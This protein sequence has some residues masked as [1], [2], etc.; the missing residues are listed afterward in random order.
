MSQMESIIAGLL[1]TWIIG[2]EIGHAVLGHDPGASG[3]QSKRH[4]R[5][6]DL[7][8][9][10]RLPKFQDVVELGYFGITQLLYNWIRYELKT[11]PVDFGASDYIGAI[12][13]LR[14][15]CPTHPPML[16]RLLDLM[17]TFLERFPKLDKTG[18]FNR[19]RSRVEVV[20][21]ALPNWD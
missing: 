13:V 19:V 6:A 11:D 2:H 18:Y 10:E 1:Y 14:D 17:D 9:L 21:T 12:Q 15:D 4:E 7:F 5:E 20:R 16:I 3:R 8:F